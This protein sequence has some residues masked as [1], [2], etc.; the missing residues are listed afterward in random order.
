MTHFKAR[1]RSTHFV[2]AALGVGL[3]WSAGSL[4]QA[5]DLTITG[6]PVG[7]D[8]YET[9]A[10]GSL[11]VEQ[12]AD[13]ANPTPQEVVAAAQADYGRLL[14]VLYDNGYFGPVIK[15][16]LDGVDAADIPPVQPPR[17]IN[18]AVIAVDPGPEFLSLI[19]I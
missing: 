4:T 11:L 19:H 1:F 18:Q 2:S 10:G 7:S 8:L 17:Q 15:I 12:T 13:D 16:T 14:A 6:I 9:L 3:I 5:A